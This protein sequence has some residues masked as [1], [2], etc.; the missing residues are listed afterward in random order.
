MCFALCT[1]YCANAQMEEQH[2]IPQQISSYQFRL[3]GDMTIKQFFQVAAGALIALLLYASSLPDYIRWPGII[4]S[5]LAGVALAFFPIQDRPLSVWIKLFFLSI[6]SPTLYVWKKG[7]KQDYFQPETSTPVTVSEIPLST[8]PTATPAT[9]PEPVKL[10]PTPLIPADVNVSMLDNL[11]E[12]E[13]PVKTPVKPLTSKPVFSAKDKQREELKVP[14]TPK[15]SVEKSEKDFST[16]QTGEVKQEINSPSYVSPSVGRKIVGAK[17]ASFSLGAAPPTPPT[18]PNVVVGQV[19]DVSG[20]IIENA[21][22][23]I[24]DEN[25]RSV[26]A[27]RSNKLGHFM[28]VT[29]LDNGIYQLITEKEGYVFEPVTVNLNGTI[30][31]P[32]A[33]KAGGNTEKTPVGTSSQTVYSQ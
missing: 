19:M 29:P 10:A 27:L 9:P 6:Y 2:P 14:T 8:Q 20:N 22:L 28:I 33:I 32:I 31:S 12:G 15:L 21:I 25:G 26:R 13:G 4:F 30:L 1:L 23:E 7:V 5:F 24:K 17:D 11:L 16:P 18:T 3:V